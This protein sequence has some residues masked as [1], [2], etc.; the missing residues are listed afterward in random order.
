MKKSSVTIYSPA[1]ELPVI[2]R[3]L[4]R[5]ANRIRISSTAV[6]TISNIV[7]PPSEEMIERLNQLGKQYPFC[8]YYKQK[9]HD[10]L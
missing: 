5:R 8:V 4:T 9:D 1:M 6:E 7:P 2:S 3:R 10:P